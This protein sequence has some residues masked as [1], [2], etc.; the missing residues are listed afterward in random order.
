MA[1]SIY[2]SF[3]LLPVPRTFPEILPESFVKIGACAI[4]YK[5]RDSFQRDPD[6]HSSDGRLPANEPCVENE[7]KILRFSF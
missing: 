4:A 5:F 2:L 7:E 1:I 6:F 3:S